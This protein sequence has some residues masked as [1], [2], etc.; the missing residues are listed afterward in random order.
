MYLQIGTLLFEIQSNMKEC[1]LFFNQPKFKPFHISRPIKGR[2][3]YQFIVNEDATR[4]K[5]SNNVLS[6]TYNKASEAI[7]S[8][9]QDQY[10]LN[11]LFDLVNPNTSVNLLEETD[12][13]SSKCYINDN[14]TLLYIYPGALSVF[15]FDK[16]KAILYWKKRHLRNIDAFNR[17][18][19]DFFTGCMI[20]N[21]EQKRLFFHSAGTV[22]NDKAYLL[23]GRSGGGKTTIS[24]IIGHNR[25][26]SDERVLVEWHNDKP[27]LTGT[28]WNGRENV[29]IPKK[30]M[31]PLERVLLLKKSK[32]IYLAPA[33]LR[34]QA[35]LLYPCLTNYGYIKK[36]GA[37]QQFLLLQQLKKQTK[38][39]LLGFNLNTTLKD[40]N[41]LL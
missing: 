39:N 16:S 8:V 17:A 28:P 22:I 2:R 13:K 12:S 23:C 14:G 27:F 6:T 38:I 5:Q 26:L 11:E 37:K 41:I 30:E 20:H 34:E 40:L 15:Q 35:E 18:F 10:I 36:H 21:N 3:V 29:I 19:Y 32:K 7:K 33:S 24:N 9:C 4:Q 31:Y 25:I 1:E